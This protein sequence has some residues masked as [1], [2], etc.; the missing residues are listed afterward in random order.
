[1]GGAIE[2]GDVQR[3]SFTA[4]AATQ[5]VRILLFS[6]TGPTSTCTCTTRRGIT[7]A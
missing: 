3:I 2:E 5:V 6:P 1:M 7:W 4:D